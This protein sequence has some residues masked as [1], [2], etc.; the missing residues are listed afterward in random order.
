MAAVPGC[1][2]LTY[3][4]ASSS[5]YYFLLNFNIRPRKNVAPFWWWASWRVNRIEN[6][7]FFFGSTSMLRL[8]TATLQQI[9][10]ILRPA[11]LNYLSQH[12]GQCFNSFLSPK[13]IYWRSVWLRYEAFQTLP[14]RTKW[15]KGFFSKVNAAPLPFSELKRHKN[16]SP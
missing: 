16:T 5:V 12:S 2:G 11:S 15:L 1:N 8:L 14:I 3:L 9:L 6:A 7:L 10:N 4:I 13:H